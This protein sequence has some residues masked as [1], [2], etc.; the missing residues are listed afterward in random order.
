MRKIR[1]T[2][3]NNDLKGPKKRTKENKGKRERKS[4]K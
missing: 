1:K 2:S 3:E 4:G